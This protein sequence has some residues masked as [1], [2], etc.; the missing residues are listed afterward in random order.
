M[1]S[2]VD[3]LEPGAVFAFRGGTEKVLEL[4]AKTIETVDADRFVTWGNEQFVQAVA[5]G[6]I[7]D[8]QDRRTI[9]RP[10]KPPLADKIGHRD[11][12][13]FLSL[14]LDAGGGDLGVARDHVLRWARAIRTSGEVEPWQHVVGLALIDLGA[15]CFGHGVGVAFPA[16]K[17]RPSKNREDAAETQ[18]LIQRFDQFIGGGEPISSQEWW[19]LRHLLETGMAAVG[20]MPPPSKRLRGRPTSRL[21]AARRIDHEAQTG[22]LSERRGGLARAIR[23][24]AKAQVL[25]ER[26]VTA[27]WRDQD[28]KQVSVPDDDPDVVER[29]KAIQ[30][31]YYVSKRRATA[32]S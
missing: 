11:I 14:C 10:G 12:D 31:N 9:R 28:H 32:N 20:M 26:Q 16:G 5:A 18:H 21:S 22:L 30:A 17:G 1:V 19:W 25:R 27:A 6:E 24:A 23:D 4:G 13:G 8:Q 29:A 3:W 15:E 2:G 7:V